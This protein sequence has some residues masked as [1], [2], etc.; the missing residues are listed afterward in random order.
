MKIKDWLYAI[1]TEPDNK[2][3][4]PIRLIGIVGTVFALVL[5]GHSVFVLHQPFD[6]QAYGIGFGALMATLGVAMGV[7]SDSPTDKKE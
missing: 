7:K 6:L 3:P 2:T 5:T 4:C 1:T